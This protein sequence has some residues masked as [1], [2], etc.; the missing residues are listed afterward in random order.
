MMYLMGFG[1]FLKNL[2]H[3]TFIWAILVSAYLDLIEL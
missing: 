1:G 2:F 3:F